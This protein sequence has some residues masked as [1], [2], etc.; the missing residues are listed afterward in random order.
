MVSNEQKHVKISL[1]C[2]VKNE[3]TSI[4]NFLDTILNQSRLPDEIIIVDGGSQDGTIEIIRSYQERYPGLIKLIV[5]PNANIAKGRNIAI[6]N[7]K[8]EY[9]AS[10]DAGT[11]YPPDWLQNLALWFEKD[12][13]VD[14]VAGF[15]EP[16]IE[17][18]YDECVGM[19]LYPKKDLMNWNKFLPS[20]RSV[21]FKKKVW[22]NL[23]GFAEWLPKGI[24]EDTDFFI[25]A[26]KAGYKFAYAKNATCYWKPRKNLYEL[27]KQYLFYSIGACMGGHT[28]T[29]LFESYGTNPILFVLPTLIQFIKKGKFIHFIL[30]IVI[31]MTVFLA[32][33]IGT[34]TCII[35]KHTRRCSLN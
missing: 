13:S 19:L 25:R 16:K 20:C 7:A 15:F 33:L 22:E 3:A 14:I 27:F 23:G 1:C 9:I 17:N 6:K 29:F 31:L 35:Q 34:V 26:R 28:L 32:K 4:K 21:A 2:T 12:P 10:A 24:G 5:V 30:S 18:L 11:E 8:Y